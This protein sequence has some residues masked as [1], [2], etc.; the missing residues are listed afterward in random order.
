MLVENENGHYVYLGSNLDQFIADADPLTA[1]QSETSGQIE[2][3]NRGVTSTGKA[4]LALTLKE[5]DRPAKTLVISALV[6]AF[7]KADAKTKLKSGFDPDDLIGMHFNRGKRKT[8]IREAAKSKIGAPSK[9][10][11]VTEVQE[12]AE[13]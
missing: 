10:T 13:A 6:A 5:Q 3:V 7:G 11:E 1:W 8:E 4:Y 2:F 12:V 9:E